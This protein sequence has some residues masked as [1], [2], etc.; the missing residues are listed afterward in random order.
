MF[1]HNFETSFSC[2][3]NV[4]IRSFSEFTNVFIALFNGI[5]ENLIGC[6][7][8]AETIPLL[9]NVDNRWYVSVRAIFRD[10]HTSGAVFEPYFPKKMYT[11]D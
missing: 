1:S 10:L 2:F 7:N 5:A 6:S 9:C 3:S 8:V 11:F 4:L